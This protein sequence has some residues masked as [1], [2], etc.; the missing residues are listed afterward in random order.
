MLL[1]HL[2]PALSLTTTVLTL[3]LPF[4]TNHA[5]QPQDQLTLTIP[6]NPNPPSP[7]S[8][9][10]IKDDSSCDGTGLIPPTNPNNHCTGDGLIPPS[11]PS[12]SPIPPI[13][14]PD[15][16]RENFTFENPTLECP[17]P[18]QPHIWDSFKTLEKDMTKLFTL[19][20]KNVSF[21]VVGH[22]P[23]AGHYTDLLHFYVN[24]LRRVSVLFMDHKERFEIHPVAI[25]GGCESRWSVQEVRFRGVMNSGD[26]FDIINVWVTRWHENQMVEVRTYIDAPKIMDAL[27]KNEIWW[28]GTTER[29]NWRYMPGPAGMP[30]LKELEGYMGYPDGRRYED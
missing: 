6:P 3:T 7:P 29:E 10:N 16:T 4:N 27:H 21:T 24:A 23:I 28:N 15:P 9:P 14:T 25:H 5:H 20:H 22:H 11:P 2:L 1:Q 17:Y 8:P 19:I 18:S 12:P 30:D 26:A 13:L